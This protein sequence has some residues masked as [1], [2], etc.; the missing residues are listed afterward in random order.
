MRHIV[1]MVMMVAALAGHAEADAIRA[2][3]P[4][5]GAVPVMQF[6]TTAHPEAALVRVRHVQAEWDIYAPPATLELRVNAGRADVRYTAVPFGTNVVEFVAEDGRIVAAQTLEKLVAQH[7]CQ[8][9]RVDY[10]NVLFATSIYHGLIGLTNVIGEEGS[11]PV[12][13][14]R[15]PQL[16][17]H[18]ARRAADGRGAT[19][20]FSC[21]YDGTFA[22]WSGTHRVVARNPYR[23]GEVRTVTLDADELALLG[24]Q[25]TV[26]LENGYIVAMSPIKWDTETEGT[27]SHAAAGTGGKEGTAEGRARWQDIAEH[28]AAADNVLRGCTVTR[29]IVRAFPHADGSGHIAI[30][31]TAESDNAP[32]RKDAPGVF[33][34]AGIVATGMWLRMHL[35]ADA[36]REIYRYKDRVPEVRVQ[37]VARWHLQ[38]ESGRYR[39]TVRMVAREVPV[40]FSAALSEGRAP[41]AI[42]ISWGD[43][44]LV[45][46]PD[47]VW[48]RSADGE[49]TGTLAG[50]GPAA[51]LVQ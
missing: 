26:R 50:H 1:M 47:M 2:L 41:L 43:T 28:K 22:V 33:D 27:S 14:G 42:R 31:L 44:T 19:V 35:P 17:I 20:R 11:V 12:H 24:A 29:C 3:V 10:T 16:T 15:Y 49:W 5:D 39:A 8:Y 38:R 9:V 30:E 45:W 34:A 23:A 21:Q 18:E 4:Q 40:H 51:E 32:E 7:G 36:P 25:A 37:G 46:Q 6:D 13:Y 48:T